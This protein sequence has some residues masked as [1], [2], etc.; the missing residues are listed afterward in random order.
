MGQIS[1]A[2]AVG[3]SGAQKHGNVASRLFSPK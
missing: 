1:G 3:T 2:E